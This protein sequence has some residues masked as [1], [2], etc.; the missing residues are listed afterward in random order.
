MVVDSYRGHRAG[1]ITAIIEYFRTGGD[2]G[3]TYTLVVFLAGLIVAVALLSLKVRELSR[4]GGETQATEV[5]PSENEVA[6]TT[7]KDPLWPY[8]LDTARPW[9]P[10]TTEELVGKVTGITD[11][12]AQEAIKDELGKWLRVRGNIRNVHQ[13]SGDIDAVVALTTRIRV[14][15]S[16]DSK[17]WTDILLNSKIDDEIE[18]IGPITRVD[19]AGWIEVEVRQLL[20]PKKI[21]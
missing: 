19:P 8:S 4:T 15:L 5:A 21:N 10:F 9:S 16:A 18:A 6:V 20:P 14:F 3:T 12:Q 13:S 1:G 2:A 17:P 11:A 7:A